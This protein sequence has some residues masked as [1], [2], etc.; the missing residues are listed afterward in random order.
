MSFISNIR[1]WVDGNDREIARLRKIAVR[2]NELEPKMTALAMRR[3]RAKTVEFKQRLDQG[4]TLDDLLVEAFAVC[5]EAARRTLNMRHFDVQLIG[6]M[7]LHEGKVAEMRTG[8]GKTLVATLPFYLNAL[9]GRG[10]HLVTTND[11]L[12]KRDAEWMGPIYG[13]LGLSVGMIQHFLPPPE[14]RAAYAADITYVTNN[15]AGFDYLRDNMAPHRAIACSAISTTPS[16]TRSTRSSST[17]RAR[18]SSSAARRKRCSGRIIRMR[19]TSTSISR[20]TSCRSCARTRTTPSTRRCTRCR[21]PRPASPRSSGCSACTT[22]TTHRTWSRRTNCRPRSRPKS[23]SA[24][25]SNTWSRTA[26][27]S[28]WMS[29]PAGSC[30]AAATRTASTRRSKR[31][32]ASRSRARIR[33]SPPSPSRTISASTRSSPA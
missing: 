18:R 16:S 14:R 8:E 33:R 32:K 30:T 29:S 10:V 25:T 4:A 1:S 23:S 20:A 21:S 13:F 31:R 26:R 28:S 12:A 15:E 19:R 7:V 17:R 22:C 24:K 2:I 27:S 3:S 9:T 11:Y 5:R 6:G